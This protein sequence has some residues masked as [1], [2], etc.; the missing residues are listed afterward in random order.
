MRSD[1]LVRRG[2]ARAL[3]IASAVAVVALA[4]CGREP[5]V[6]VYVSADESVARPVFERFERETGI[7][8][9]AKFDTEATKTTGLASLLR[10]EKDRPRADVFWSNEQAANVALAAEGV[11][12]PPN[13]SEE[14]MAAIAR[15]PSAWKS[16]DG[17]WAALAGRARVVVYSPDR[18][19]EPPQ[20]WTALIAPRWKGRIAMAD[21]RFGTTRGHFGAMKAYWDA[22]ALPGYFEAFA[23]GLAENDPALLTSGNAGV[24]DAVAR[25]EADIGLTD[26]DDVLAAQARGLKV[27]MAFPRHAREPSTAGGGT[28]VIPNTVAMVARCPHPAEA[29]RFL[30]WFVAESTERQLAD[31]PAKHAPLVGAARDGDLVVADPLSV[32]PAASSA[33]ADAAVEAFLQAVRD[34]AGNR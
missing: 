18:V 16:A 20:T 21:P 30:A 15:W 28:F 32:D 17:T 2:A 6:T 26:T 13:G 33:V 5:S 31:M 3:S 22:N 4:A 23:E 27:A 1:S 9:D 34:A 12:A 8:V 24:V 29:G 11:T 14:A 10:A 7:R 25:G 19:S